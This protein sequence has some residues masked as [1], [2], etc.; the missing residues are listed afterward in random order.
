MANDVASQEVDYRQVAER[1]LQQLDWT[2]DFLYS[3]RKPDIASA[4]AKNCS[5]IRRRM[6]EAV[7]SED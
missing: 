4:I 5:V 1:T 2:I 7:T 3:I 6:T